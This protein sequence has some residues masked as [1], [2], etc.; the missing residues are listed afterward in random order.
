MKW[1]LKIILALIIIM[2]IGVLGISGFLGYS[3]TKLKRIPVEE[4]PA[5]LG[6]NYEEVSFSS[7]VDELTLRGWY[8]P[9]SVRLIFSNNITAFL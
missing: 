2:V 9:A 7:T 4:N 6:L 5:L 8:L 3:M 1:W